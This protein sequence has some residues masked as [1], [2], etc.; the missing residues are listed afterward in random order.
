MLHKLIRPTT[1]EKEILVRCLEESMLSAGTSC[2]YLENSIFAD[3]VMEKLNNTKMDKD[4]LRMFARHL[5]VTVGP[6]TVKTDD[7][8][9]YGEVRIGF[10]GCGKPIVF[11]G[12]EITEEL[13][14]EFIIEKALSIWNE[15]YNGIDPQLAP[16]IEAM[17]DKIGQIAKLMIDINELWMDTEDRECG[18]ISGYE[19]IYS[20]KYPWSS[21]L[22]E[23]SFQ[24][25]K[26]ASEM[27][28]SAELVR[29]WEKYGY[30]PNTTQL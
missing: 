12:R 18:N 6:E 1:K 16:N 23:E 25:M 4:A 27:K 17:A 13:S 10:T 7:D 28:C 21:D 11:N 14:N 22:M 30:E 20:N 19:V 5:N 29:V 15:S 24:V 9:D 8:T 3:E 26:W 2:S